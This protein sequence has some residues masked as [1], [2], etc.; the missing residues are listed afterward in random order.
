MTAEG[1]AAEE[2]TLKAG[3]IGIGGWL[4]LPLLGLFLAPVRGVQY[5]A[6]YGEVIAAWP[7][8]GLSQSL[9]TVFELMSTAILLFAAHAILLLFMFKRL[10]IFPGWFMVW[11]A[12]FPP[13]QIADPILVYLA[14]PEAFS[15]S[16]SVIFDGESVREISRSVWA[17]A[18]WIPYMM[19]SKRVA[20]TFVN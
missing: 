3:P 19:R 12:T 8:H 18:I 9:V 5:F 16:D 2:G 7:F 11:G 4:L 13:V 10:Q 1:A 14:F 6:S 17:C 15:D 20:N